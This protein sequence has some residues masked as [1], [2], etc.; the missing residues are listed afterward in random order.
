MDILT[1]QISP[2]ITESQTYFFTDFNEARETRAND[3]DDDGNA[4]SMANHL[5]LASS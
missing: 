2:C 3:T 4:S 1:L 5:S